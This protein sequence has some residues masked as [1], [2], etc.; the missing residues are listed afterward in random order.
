M[1]GSLEATPCVSSS[2]A[3]LIQ[4]RG[5]FFFVPVYKF[6]IR[7]TN[8]CLG[9][10]FR[11]RIRIRRSIPVK[12]FLKSHLALVYPDQ[13]HAK[14]ARG[15]DLFCF[16][17]HFIPLDINFHTVKFTTTIVNPRR[18]KGSPLCQ[19]PSDRFAAPPTPPPLGPVAPVGVPNRSATRRWT[20]PSGTL[21]R[22]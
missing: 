21:T 17:L 14:L 22:G 10:E 3:E 12:Q 19:P 13:E 6:H 2:G 16:F 7:H 20:P 15:F 5:Y 18:P 4:N 11:T 8:T 9:Y 1:G